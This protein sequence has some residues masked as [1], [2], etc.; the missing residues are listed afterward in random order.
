[1]TDEP[2]ET[3]SEGQTRECGLAEI[4]E[5]SSTVDDHEHEPKWTRRAREIGE[6]T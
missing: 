5:Q 4:D 3:L 2:G 6:A 1:M